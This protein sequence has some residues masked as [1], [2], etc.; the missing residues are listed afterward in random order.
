MSLQDPSHNLLT[1]QPETHA[2]KPPVSAR[3]ILAN[4]KNALRST[5]PKAL[6]GKHTVS[7]NAIKHGLLAREVVITAG[8]GEESPKSFML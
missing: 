1:P 3:K 4:R 8:D 6:R 7:R 2:D 5:G